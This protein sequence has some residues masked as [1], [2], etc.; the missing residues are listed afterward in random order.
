M[1]WVDSFF[2]C[3][4]IAADSDAPPRTDDRSPDTTHHP[5]HPIAG[6]GTLDGCYGPEHAAHGDGGVWVPLFA[7]S[8]GRCEAWLMIVEKA[9]AKLNGGYDTLDGGTVDAALSL[10]TGGSKHLHPRPHTHP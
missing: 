2:P 7:Q 10:L 4:W 8:G 5:S 3:E 9:Y 6:G 1:V